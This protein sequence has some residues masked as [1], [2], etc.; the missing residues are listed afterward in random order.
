[1]SVLCLFLAVISGYLG[2][3]CPVDSGTQDAMYFFAVV[4]GVSSIWL[5][6]WE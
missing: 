2:L 6:I 4:T 5:F 1:M 3:H